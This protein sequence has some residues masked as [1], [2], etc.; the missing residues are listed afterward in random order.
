[1]KSSRSARTGFPMTIS[2]Y[3]KILLDLL[4]EQETAV[5]KIYGFY[6]ERFP[7]HQA[8]WR[9]LSHDERNH[10]IWI[11]SLRKGLEKGSVKI[12]PNH[13]KLEELG[14]FTKVLKERLGEAEA[15][16]LSASQAFRYA[17][18]IESGLLEEPFKKVFV[19]STEK[20]NQLLDKL[21]EQTQRHAEMIRE[22]MKKVG[23][24]DPWGLEKTGEGLKPRK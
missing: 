4:E 1:M 7:E 15:G 6:A 24:E 21:V 2:N 12:D 13:L 10:A 16:L 11:H 18:W 3:D 20:A 9:Q 14:K 17:A 8:F 5:S 19:A 23:P 22:I